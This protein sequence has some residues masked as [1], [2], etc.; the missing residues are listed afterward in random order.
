MTIMFMASLVVGGKDMYQEMNFERTPALRWKLN[1]IYAIVPI[2]GAAMFM[3]HL[4][5][6]IDHLAALFKD[7][8]DGD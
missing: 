3:I 4:R 7:S 2:S 5:Q 8:R 6:L 1:I